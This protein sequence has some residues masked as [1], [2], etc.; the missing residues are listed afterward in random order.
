MEGG[1][2][3]DGSIPGTGLFQGQGWRGSREGAGVV[4]GPSGAFRSVLERS[5]S[6]L[7]RSGSIQERSRSVLERSRSIP[8][9]FRSVP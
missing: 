5:R 3:R 9:E 6:V 7:E 4:L 8:G 2:I 1:L